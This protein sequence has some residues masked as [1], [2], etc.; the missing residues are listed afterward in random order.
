MY[1][2]MLTSHTRNRTNKHMFTDVAAEPAT[3]AP[4]QSLTTNTGPPALPTI[5]L[6][7]T[8]RANETKTDVEHETPHYCSTKQTAEL[9][10]T[11]LNVSHRTMR[12]RRVQIAEVRHTRG[13][14]SLL[15][16]LLPCFPS[17]LLRL[18]PL[19]Q[20]RQ[21]PSRLRRGNDRGCW[22]RY[23]RLHVA[24]LRRGRPRRDGGDL[25]FLLAAGRDKHTSGNGIACGDG[26][27][28]RETVEARS[29]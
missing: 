12:S 11:H 22:R 24:G 1:K 14:R 7:W 26:G 19:L 3:L 13:N 6:P 9:T 28:E 8:T 4:W 16:R 20:L 2:N 21:V 29:G 5:K 15:L 25:L 23:V 27:G 10:A 18:P 17:L